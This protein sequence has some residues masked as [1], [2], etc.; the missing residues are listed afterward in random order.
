MGW[1]VVMGCV[2][3]WC[4]VRGGAGLGLGEEV[5]GDGGGLL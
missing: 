4:E 3:M 5:S 2:V 1:V